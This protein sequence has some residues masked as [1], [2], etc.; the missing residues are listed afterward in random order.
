M[1]RGDASIPSTTLLDR[2]PEP[3]RRL[4]IDGLDDVPWGAHLCQFYENNTDLLEIL[5]P[6]F[7]AGLTS[8]EFC[9]WV[10]SEPLGSYEA[11]AALQHAVPQLVEFFAKGQIEILDYRDW[12]KATG[13]FDGD[14]VHQGWLD[15]LDAA[16]E[17]G[18]DGLRLTGDTFWLMDEEWDH[19][20][21]YEARLDPVVRSSRILAIC[22]YSL[23]K[24][25]TRRILD[26]I[27]NHDFALMKEGGRW[28]AF[29]SFARR[30]TE[31]ALRESEIR[32]RLTVEGVNDGIMTVDENCV[33]TLVNSAALRMF[34]YA[35][36]ELFGKSIDTIMSQ[37]LRGAQNSN[38][39]DCLRLGKEMIIGRTLEGEGKRA[40][41]SLFPLEWTITE[42]LFDHQRVFVICMR[43]LT[44]RREKEALL[45]ELH[46]DRLA[47]VGGM[48]SALAHE[49]NQPLTA[50]VAYLNAAQRLLHIPPER[51]PTNIES[52]LG[53]AAEEALR[54][55]KIITHMREFVSR[56]EPDK[57]IQN[58]HDVIIAACDLIV[59]TAKNFNVQII[60]NLNAQNDRVVIDRVQITQ[61]LVNLKRNA[62]EA[63]QA[64]GSH[65]IIVSTSSIDNGMIRT[66]IADR[67]SGLSEEIRAHMFQP[68][69]TSKANGMGV[70]LSISRSIIEAHYG[71]IW[72]EP[73]P[74]GGSIF[75]FTLPADMGQ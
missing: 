49:I 8:N 20:I 44:E 54:A 34:G 22:T 70:G 25:G 4:G 13:C 1:I 32:L 64:S 23:E 33:V 15:K 61:V 30:R 31:D 55:G 40:D 39:A 37:P 10:T 19:F 47:A 63:M 29:K 57:T 9:M 43:D 72:A 42:V 16:R 26:A 53:K 62:V 45:Q 68:F 52:T 75:S 48:A 17:R 38:L 67:G 59:P 46:A 60:L 18:F 58:L 27:A 50:T 28:Q 66:D 24:C 71:A 11:K 5:V 14:R 36:S 73:N 6:Y 3:L 56:N 51:R 41:G 21:H 2:T 7:E 12:Y 69:K 35:S 74:A 65:E